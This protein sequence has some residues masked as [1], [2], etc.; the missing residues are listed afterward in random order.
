MFF[1]HCPLSF[2]HCQLSFVYFPLSFVHCQL[3][4]VF[5]RC[6]LPLFNVHCPCELYIVYFLRFFV[7]LSIFSVNFLSMS[8][9][10]IHCL[11][12][13]FNVH[14][15][16]SCSLSIF[17]VHYLYSLS[18]VFIQC[19]LSLLT[20]HAKSLYPIHCHVTCIFSPYSITQCPLSIYICTS[21]KHL[22]FHI[23]SIFYLFSYVC[24]IFLYILLY[25]ARSP[26]EYINKLP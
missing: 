10:F 23:F 19:Q 22:P 4:I 7:H 24:Y 5:V 6:T 3:S 2:V 1:V 26:T 13:L 12:S 17:T 14:C 18:V 8:V 20:V 15:L 21:Y 16:F 9:V 25:A 11:L